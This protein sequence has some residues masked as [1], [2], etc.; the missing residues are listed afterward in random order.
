MSWFTDNPMPVFVICGITLLVLLGLLL[1]TG[2]GV[3]LLAMAGVM[4]CI[5]TAIVIDSLVVTDRELV[6]QTLYDAAT[7]AETNNLDLMAKF[8]S[9]SVPHLNGQIRS[10][11]SQAVLESVNLNSIDIEVNE[12]KK[13]PT[14]VAN[15]WFVARGH[16]KRGDTVY[17]NFPGRLTVNFQKEGTRWLVTDY[18]R[19]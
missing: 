14:A 5:V 13:P 18:Q 11:I 1:K 8:I 17:N 4:L 12:S 7:A 9:P 3:I 6:E 2:R 16:L 10:W 19:H 15:F